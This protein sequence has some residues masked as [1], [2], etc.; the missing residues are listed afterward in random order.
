MTMRPNSQKFYRISPR[1]GIAI[2][3]IPNMLTCPVSETLLVA[4]LPKGLALRVTRTHKPSTTTKC[5]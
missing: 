3:L 4:M 1:L 5:R 2:L